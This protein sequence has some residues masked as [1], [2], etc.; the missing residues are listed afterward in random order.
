MISREAS[1]PPENSAP[2]TPAPIEHGYTPPPNRKRK[3][4]AISRAAAPSPAP[5]DPGFPGSQTGESGLVAATVLSSAGRPRLTESRGPTFVPVSEGSVYHTTEQIAMNRLGFRYTYAG[6]APEGSKI[7]Y[8]TIE[9]R[10]AGYVRVSWEDRN[11]LMKVTADGLGLCGDKGWRSA[12][13]NVPVRE[14]QWYMEFK[15]VLGGGE[16]SADSST[17]EGAHVRLGWGRRE[18]RTDGPIGLD[19]YSY[20]YRDKTGDKVT[21][22]RP[23]PY[24]EPFKTGDVVGL[25]ISL[26]SKRKPKSNDPYDPA[27]MKRERIAIDFKGQ[28][29]FESLEYPQ[30]KE[31]ISLMNS[32]SDKSK[33]TAPV[34]SSSKKSA[35]VKNIS[36][37]G[38]GKN[39]AS[40]EPT[41]QPLPVLHNSSIAFFVNGKSQG[42]AFRDLY[43]YLQLRKVTTARK[44]KNK[45]RLREGM[46]EHAE[47]N[48]DDGHLGYYPFISLFNN[49]Q[50]HI[51]AGPDFECPPP[52]D[53]EGSLAG[54]PESTDTKERNWRPLCERYAE[55][56]QEQWDM[57]A[58]EEKAAQEKALKAEKEEKHKA[59]T[60]EPRVPTPAPS[61]PRP[62]QKSHPKTM[63]IKTAEIKTVESKTVESKAAETIETKGTPQPPSLPPTVHPSLLLPS[64][65]ESSTSS[66]SMFSA[67]T[68]T[69]PNLE[70]T[71]AEAKAAARRERKRVLERA[72]RARKAEE[73]RNAKA[74]EKEAQEALLQQQAMQSP[75]PAL[76][77]QDAATQLEDYVM[78]DYPA[79][80]EDPPIDPS[81]MDQD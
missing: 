37:R 9:S 53:I 42:V 15:I 48:F 22:S 60:E 73:L 32:T 79:N 10:P 68:Q 57:D 45:K 50:V 25:Y 64:Q 61:R 76:T 29:V 55:F 77:A 81:L 3:H 36:E 19:G 67:R 44:D 8:R 27:H 39:T 46:T 33:S 38:R 78:G 20:G 56:M 54:D 49:A 13:L 43:D 2:S 62:P 16:K 18:A 52:A 34:P 51:N 65:S 74:K 35:T 58:V 7:P 47:N 30:S 5:S 14:G 31:M 59:N 21:L 6:L 23:R 40:E 12:R 66:M 75:P 28:E 41:M 4:A 24:G 80:P 11:P 69:P 26:P 70:M 1:S 72:R 17:K 63:E 71:E